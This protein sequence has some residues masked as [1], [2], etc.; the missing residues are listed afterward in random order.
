M[1]AHRAFKRIIYR[2]AIKSITREKLG[3]SASGIT[4]EGSSVD[5]KY[6]QAPSLITNDARGPGPFS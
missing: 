3:T 1:F 5:L 2:Y 4:S 6:L